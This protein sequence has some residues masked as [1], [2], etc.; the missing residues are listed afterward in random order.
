MTG[1]APLTADALALVLRAGERVVVGDADALDALL[2]DDARPLAV[3]NEN[4]L[5]DIP[6]GV[7]LREAARFAHA[8]GF[9]FP[10]GDPVPDLALSDACFAMP[11]FV[12]AFVAHAELVTHDGVRLSTPRAP[13]S[14]TGPDLL[15]LAIIDPPLAVVVRARV[16]VCP[17][18]I[19]RTRE[20]LHATP[21]DVAS[22]VR[23]LLHEGR[24]FVVEAARLRVRVLGPGAANARAVDDTG[25][26]PEVR[27]ARAI[28]ASED[29]LVDA[30]IGGARI[31]A[32]PLMG[33]V[34]IF[35]DESRVATLAKRDADVR[36]WR[37]DKPAVRSR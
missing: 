9:A 34:A 13:R 37:V 27:G 8:N 31:I 7:T 12:D 18:E 36:A 25:T 1:R 26:F 23:S 22:R 29:A 15:G 19:A 4:C 28:V 24:A 14:A 21:L 35:D 16:R 3:D 17:L 11:A 30:L 5:L 10:V 33:R 2:V 32:S 6:G 20:E